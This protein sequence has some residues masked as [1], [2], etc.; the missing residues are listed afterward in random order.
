[1][2]TKSK[3]IQIS[4]VTLVKEFKLLI[5]F[6]DGKQQ[7]INFEPFLAASLHPE[8]K[9]YLQPKNFKKFRVEN[10]ELMWGDFDL[11]FPIIDLYENKIERSYNKIS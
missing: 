10:G 7:I 2:N 9:K 4:K 6:S 5:E 3:T 11:L 8:I 1:M